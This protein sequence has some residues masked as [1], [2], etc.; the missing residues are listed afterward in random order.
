MKTGKVDMVISGM[1]ATPERAKQVEFSKSYTEEKQIMVVKKD[2]ASKYKNVADFS[3]KKVGAQ[4]QS[5]QEQIA[6]AELQAP[7]SCRSKKP[8]T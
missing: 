7:K 5:T 3:G 4:K 6:K 2:Q 8:M 1:S